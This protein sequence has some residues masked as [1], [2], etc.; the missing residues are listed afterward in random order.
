MHPP[1]T[2]QDRTSPAPGHGVYMRGA[3]PHRA[4]ISLCD[5]APQSR[6]PLPQ[7]DLRAALGGEYSPLGARM[8][9][10]GPRSPWGF[11]IRV[12]TVAWTF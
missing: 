1:R 2:C 8:G 10:R 11:T 12:S 6:A 7:L 5:Q 9:Q 4:G 3:A